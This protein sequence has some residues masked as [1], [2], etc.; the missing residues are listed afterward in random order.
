MWI[1]LRLI[2]FL[3]QRRTAKSLHA[4]LKMLIFPNFAGFQNLFSKIGQK[5]KKIKRRIIHIPITNT[6]A[7]EVGPLLHF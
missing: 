5:I 6:T 2:F 1:I 4:A 3:K 7:L